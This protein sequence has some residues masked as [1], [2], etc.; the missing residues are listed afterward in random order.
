M[1]QLVV[2]EI[3]VDLS[4][5]HPSVPNEI[6]PNHEF[7]MGLI[8]PK[9]AGKTTL[10]CNLLNYY[11]GYFHNII[12]FSPTVKNDE[13]WDW[14]K[15]QPLLGDNAK[16]RRWFKAKSK[17]EEGIVDKPNHK[18]ELADKYCKRRTTEGGKLDL[19]IPEECF[20]HDYDSSTLLNMVAE[21]QE[22]IDLLKEEGETKHIANRLLFLFD[23]LV[24]SSLF[25]NERKN[26]FK[27]LNTTHRHLSCSIIMVS[28]AYME[29]PKTVRTQYSCL[30]LFEIYNDQE[31][32]AIV[33]EYPM[34]M[35]A[36]QWME[37]YRYCT[38]DPHSFMFYNIQKPKALRV[39]KNFSEILMF[40][41]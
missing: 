32:A 10:I 7:T 35:S 37:A 16:L 27:I 21:Q 9:G 40:K 24:G 15:K 12:V 33:K 38:R 6:L 39:M 30:I 41:E 3:P 1:K 2:K 4:S 25:G 22:L 28:Q 20:I 5:K 29:I 8:A 18:D 17:R 11:K 19:T 31:I 36:N 26:P 34:A 23:D 13:K 14:V